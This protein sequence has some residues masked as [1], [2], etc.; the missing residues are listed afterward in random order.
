[1]SEKQ[2]TL[3]FRRNGDMGYLFCFTKVILLGHFPVKRLTSEFET[4]IN[5]SVAN[6]KQRKFE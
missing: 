5:L 1:M 2:E 4:V 6:L 3:H